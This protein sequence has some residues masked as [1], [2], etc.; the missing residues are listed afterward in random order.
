[1]TF[2]TSSSTPLY[3]S[4]WS[5]RSTGQYAGTCVFLILL[6]AFVRSLFAL[7]LLTEK[8]WLDQALRRRY[9]VVAGARPEPERIGENGDAKTATLLTKRGVEETVRV[10]RNDAREVQP[11]RLSVDV[12]RAAMVTVTVGFAYLL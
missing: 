9:I 4:A 12:P 2:G 8:R 5:P 3:S 1:M 11:W 6:A 7:R 10:V